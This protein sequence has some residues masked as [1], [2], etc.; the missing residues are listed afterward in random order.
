MPLT[1]LDSLNLIVLLLGLLSLALY[2]Q[3]ELGVRARM[4]R[5]LEKVVKG[6]DADSRPEGEPSV[7][8]RTV[9]LLHALGRIAPLFNTA[10]RREM[11]RKLVAAGF[12][13][14]G[15]LAILMGTS[16]ASALL[17]VFLT[18]VLAWPHLDNEPLYRGLSLL[19]AAY[20]GLLM[21]RIVL[22]K[23]VARRQETIARQFPDALDLMVL[24][25]G[26]GLGLH[27]AI[28]RVAQE[29]ELLAPEVAQ[30]FALTAGQLQLNGD[31]AQALHDMAE[32]IGLDSVRSLASTLIQSR[33][34][35]TPVGDALR[36]LAKS[37]RTTRMLR[38]EEAAAK[39]ATKITLPMMLFILP[40]V[41]LI[42]AGPAFLGLMDTFG[43]FGA[44]R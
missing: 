42:A 7:L 5:R 22:D 44:S 10:Q 31:A 8:A 17:F 3:S 36:V 23:L 38:T 29:M 18:T 20:L 28:H 32:R 37:E 4:R 30:E 13:Q 24:C 40:T 9:G 27:A 26:A 41:L 34:F 39:L 35:G 15:A 2:L 16:A 14:G 11:H 1:L 12:R 21:P 19:V 33:Q 6:P 25:T 43:S